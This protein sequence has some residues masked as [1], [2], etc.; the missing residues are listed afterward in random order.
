MSLDTTLICFALLLVAV[1]YEISLQT[2]QPRK[3][4]A[5]KANPPAANEGI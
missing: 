2:R 3:A 4:E 5:Q 1:F